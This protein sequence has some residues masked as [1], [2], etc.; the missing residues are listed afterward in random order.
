MLRRSRSIPLPEPAVADGFYVMLSPF[1]AGRH[2]GS[3]PDLERRIL[4]QARPS[5]RVSVSR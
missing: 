4:N 1:R 3:A 5:S 2:T